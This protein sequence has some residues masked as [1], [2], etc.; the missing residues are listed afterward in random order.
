MF[1]TPVREIMPH[2]L[3]QYLKGWLFCGIVAT[4]IWF[5]PNMV[6]GV[7]WFLFEDAGTSGYVGGLVDNIHLPL[8]L[9]S[10]ILVLNQ[11]FLQDG[12]V[13]HQLPYLPNVDTQIKHAQIMIEDLSRKARLRLNHYP[14]LIAGEN[15]YVRPHEI[16]PKVLIS[17]YYP[18][19]LMPTNFLGK[20]TYDC[21]A[22]ERY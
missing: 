13:A 2:I 18:K 10:F 21:T 22:V 17:L 9:L 15:P 3:Y 5:I 20:F 6:H 19:I 1:F 14:Q 7:W 11:F 12:Y 16:S 4:L 8:L